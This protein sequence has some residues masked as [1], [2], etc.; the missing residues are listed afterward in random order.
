MK[1]ILT[2]PSFNFISS[3]LLRTPGSNIVDV[4]VAVSRVVQ[5][6]D[7]SHTAYRLQTQGDTVNVTFDRPDNWHQI[8][9][10]V[11]DSGHTPQVQGGLNFYEQLPEDAILQ[12]LSTKKIAFLGTARDCASRLPST[13]SK[14]GELTAL[15]AQSQIVVYENDSKDGTDTLLATY[16]QQGTLTAIQ[17]TGIATLL[18]LRTERLAYGRNRLLDFVL[19]GPSLDYVCWL[20]MDGL[21]DARFSVNGFLSNFQNESAW[22]AVFPISTP[23]YYDI[24]A[25]RDD[26]MCS[27]DVVWNSVHKYNAALSTTTTHAVVHQLAPGNIHGWVPVKSAFGGLGLYK[28]DMIGKGRYSGLQ[29]NAEI[30]EHVPYHAGLIEA[31]ARLY[32]NPNCITNMVV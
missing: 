10:E 26:V 29:G 12:N 3:L 30:C 23:L 5:P 1:Y 17:E 15:F 18:P 6:L 31:G 22:D 9:L 8:Q 4:R 13:L 28:F 20:D 27:G 21:V 14:L 16:A 2:N 24:W 11:I 19:G 25:L 7:W 32:I